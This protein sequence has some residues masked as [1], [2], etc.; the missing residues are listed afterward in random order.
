MAGAEDRQDTV[1]QSAIPCLASAQ[2]RDLPAV[3]LPLLALHRSPRMLHQLRLI[4]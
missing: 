2:A 1:I 3:P 4:S